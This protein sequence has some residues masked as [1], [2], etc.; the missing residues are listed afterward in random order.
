MCKHDEMACPRCEIPFECRIGDI[1]NCQCTGIAFSIEEKAFIEDRYQGCL[2]RECLL[3]LKQRHIL[4]I[5]K[6]F[7]HG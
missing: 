3:E 1:S 5:E 7:Y 4:F 6:Y 2:C